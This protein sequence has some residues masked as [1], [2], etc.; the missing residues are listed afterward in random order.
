LWAIDPALRKRALHDLKVA[1]LEMRSGSKSLADAIIGTWGET[2]TEIFM[3]PYNEKLWGRTLEELPSDC[4]GRYQLAFNIELAV[5]GCDGPVDYTGYSASFSYPKSGRIGDVSRALTDRVATNICYGSRVT[6][7][8]L[9]SRLCTTVLG[10]AYR[11]NELISTI[12][13]PH[14]LRFLRAPFAIDEI[15][16]YTQIAAVRIGIRGS[17]RCPYHWIYTPDRELPFYRIGFPQNVNRLTCPEGCASLLVEYA[18]PAH[19]PRAATTDIARSALQYCV[20][21]NLIEIEKS[22]L[23]TEKVISPAYVVYRAQGREKF[24]EMIDSS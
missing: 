16:D 9:R 13:L 11:F 4:C 7:I 2:I 8:D 15:F 1:Q 6:D 5:A 22:L 19:G 12:P 10:K 20:S 23:V 3:R 21:L 14:L 17:M 18:V 24:R